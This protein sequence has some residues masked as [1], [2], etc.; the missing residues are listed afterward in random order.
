MELTELFQRT[1]FGKD[2]KIDRSAEA[3]RVS[4]TRLS[5]P[6][7]GFSITRLAGN[8]SGKKVEIGIH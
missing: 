3:L 7:N 8:G 4:H 1:V 6:P 2:R 5:F